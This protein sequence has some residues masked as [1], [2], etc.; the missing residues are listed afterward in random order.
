VLDKA[1]AISRTSSKLPQP[2]LGIRQRTHCSQHLDPD[3]PRH[4]QQVHQHQ[5]RPAQH[6]QGPENDEENKGK[7]HQQ[8]G[9]GEQAIQHL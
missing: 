8:H 9:I 3:P 6:Q 1:A 7:M 2:V 4:R 5:P